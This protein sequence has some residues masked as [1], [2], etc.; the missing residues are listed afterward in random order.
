MKE[1]GI[2][3]VS[4]QDCDLND[5]IHASAVLKYFQETATLQYDRNGPTL[6]ELREKGKAFIL[7]KV[8]M[9]I[10]GLAHRFD[11]LRVETWTCANSGAAFNR[12][13]AMYNGKELIAEIHSVWALVMIADKSICKAADNPFN[14]GDEPMLKLDMP[15]RVHVPNSLA[16][17][18]AGERRIVYSDLDINNHM[19]NAYYPNMFCDFL[20]DGTMRGKRVKYISINYINES[21]AGEILK[22]YNI[23]DK[24][25]Y[26][27][28]TLRSDGSVGAE[29][30]IALTEI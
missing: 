13:G 9:M 2:F 17:N 11:S 6:A 15:A 28:K 1:A 25:G 22:I 21:A 24:D 8:N 7:S 23:H 18:Y 29:A 4:T 30:K 20:P 19:N 16:L 3:T 14:F 27:F 10:Y 26:I 5:I 12:C